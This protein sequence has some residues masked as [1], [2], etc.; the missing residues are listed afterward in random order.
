MRTRIT[1]N[2]PTPP[3]INWDSAETE[4]I[5][6][7][8]TLTTSVKH[9][10]L[11]VV[12]LTTWTDPVKPLMEKFAESPFWELDGPDPHPLEGD[13][14]IWNEEKIRNIDSIYEVGHITYQN[15]IISDESKSQF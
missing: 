6:C 15:S 2:P 3:L 4:Q 7:A 11:C 12:D 9:F 10:A 8:T 5:P 14:D 13:C 1:E